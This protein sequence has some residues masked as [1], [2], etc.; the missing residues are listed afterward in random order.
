M[1]IVERDGKLFLLIFHS[2]GVIEREHA[3]EDVFFDCSKRT[4]DER[5]S[6]LK[7]GRYI[8]WPNTEQRRNEPG[9]KSILYL[10]WRGILWVA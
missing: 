4:M 3:L 8:N 5:L 2:G 10:G 6:K 9:P 7:R 1:W